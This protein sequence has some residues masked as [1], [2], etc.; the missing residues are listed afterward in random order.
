MD[1]LLRK[2][3]SG[4][5][6]IY[7]LLLPLII[8]PKTSEIFEFNKMVFTYLITII[9]CSLWLLR[10]VINKKIIFNKTSLDSPLIIFLCSQLV[11][12][13]FSIDSRT[14]FL[15][16]YSRFNGGLL[17][18]I[19]YSL[20]YWV[21]VSNMDKVQ[22]KK[23]FYALL[24][25]T[26]ISSIWAIFEHFGHSFSCLIFPDFNKF[27]VSCWVQDVRTR[28]YS[29]FGQPNW[30][31]AWLTALI[32][33]LW[34]FQ[35]SNFKF[36][37][38]NENT[39]NKS[40]I[41]TKIEQYP[42]LLS[43]IFYL[44]SSVFFITL[45]FTKSRSGIL[46]FCISFAIFWIMVLYAQRNNF[47][48]TLLTFSLTTFY[49]L[50]TT[51]FIG[52]PWT[53]KLSELISS[54]PTTH[55]SQP[56]SPQGP[57]LEVGGGT[58]SGTIRKI[59]WTGAFDIWKKYPI[60]GS[61]VE[62][63]AYSYYGSRPVAHNL[64]S[65]W[66]YLYNKAHNEYLNYLSTTGLVGFLA[67]LF[68]IT[69]SISQ[70][71]K[72]SNKYQYP[73]NTNFKNKNHDNDIL[74][75]IGNLKL[76]NIGIISG[77]I[78]ILITNFFGF[79]VVT[80]SVL[81]FLF[82]AFAVSLGKSEQIKDESNNNLDITQKAII[83][84]LLPFT[85]YLLL[86]TRNYWY[87]DFTYAKAKLQNDSQNYQSAAK[88]LTELVKKTPSEAIYWDELAD[89]ISS[90]AI[91]ST[92]SKDSGLSTQLASSAI[93]DGNLAI[94][95]SPANV[96][97]KRKQATRLINMSA[98]DQNYLLNA[99]NIL[100]QAILQAPTDARLFYN[101]GLAYL[102]TGDYENAIKTLDKTIAMK[103]DYERA[104]YAIALIYEDINKKDKA[105]E[106]LEYIL[107]N[108]NPKNEEVK[109]ELNGL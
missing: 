103:P 75:E 38:S 50:L 45:L 77:Y 69:A 12:T 4:T 86:L 25:S 36:P 87:S 92:E 20:L 91:N 54:N 46:A 8:F 17:S 105:K 47:K 82:P 24:V 106:H 96:N 10:M 88:T 34:G 108:I 31:A 28:V 74:L 104:H 52:S 76:V 35:I 57:A 66:D 14:S 37:I 9:L 101:L 32:P 42:N 7:F 73:I 13:V 60:F 3:I 59:V 84:L 107:K 29:S 27:D 71:V 22:V 109:R 30:L 99:K 33:I 5:F 79:S 56:L 43:T 95:L 18:I 78:S 93:T 49:L 55:I 11:S 63:F 39:K 61:G 80:T 72:I 19:T 67:Y 64:V 58:E 51:L 2:L 90:L 70:I 40:Q 98:I 102:R 1:K 16:F 23:V 97:L 48:R 83:F 89:T 62:T 81:F 100:E 26:L 6:I 94:S 53:P 85:F 65:E 41:L 21:F 44:L 68:L 15:G